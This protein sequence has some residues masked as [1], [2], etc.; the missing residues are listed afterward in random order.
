MKSYS[1]WIATA[2]T[3]ALLSITS[4]AQQTKTVK[5]VAATPQPK[6]TRVRA[7]L[8]GFD[9]SPQTGKTPAQIGGVSRDL[10]AITSYAPRLGKA[11]TLTPTFFWSSDD[12]KAEFTF[13]LS[14]SSDQNTKYESK[15]KG[16]VFTYPANAPAL[17]PGATYTWSVQPTIDIGGG[18]ASASF[19]IVSG[20]DRAAIEA[21]LANVRGDRVEA[22]LA[23]AKI[24]TDSRLWYDA[25][26]AYSSLIGRFP[27]RNDLYQA[28]AQL[29]DQLP[30]TQS[31]ADAD[32]ARTQN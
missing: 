12:D 31:L 26:A 30:Q 23:Q 3:V 24:Y 18:I 4:S 21:A 25:V 1:I 14:N 29:Y 8:D 16:R 11:Y 6:P 15:V 19:V 13:M 2:L 27:K 5:P 22:S 28:R 17:T 10:G 32:I 7:K 20:Q 9:L